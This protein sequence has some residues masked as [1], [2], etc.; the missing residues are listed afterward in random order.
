MFA[1][2]RERNWSDVN[3]KVVN[4]TYRILFT[5][6]GETTKCVAYELLENG[7]GRSVRRVRRVPGTLRRRRRSGST[8]TEI[9]TS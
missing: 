6:R 5:G 2:K 1:R 8:R 9:V 4:P 7:G 3:L